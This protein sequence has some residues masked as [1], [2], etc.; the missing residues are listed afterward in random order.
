[1]EVDDGAAGG[2]AIRLVDAHR[3][4]SGWPRHDGVEH[5]ADCQWHLPGGAGAVPLLCV[6]ARLDG[7]QLLSGRQSERGGAGQQQLNLRVD[8]HGTLL[9]SARSDG[10]LPSTAATVFP[11]VGSS[12]R[13][14][15]D[16]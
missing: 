2:L 3:H 9:L 5:A 16:S 14:R 12:E 6:C 15:D 7:R 10:G 1:M 11:S 13:D 8:L 4:I